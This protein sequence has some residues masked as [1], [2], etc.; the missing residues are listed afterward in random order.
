MRIAFWITKAIATPS[1]HVIVT[2]FP[3]QQWLRECTSMLRVYLITVSFLFHIYFIDG[4]RRSL[5]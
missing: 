2:V 1:V 3:R 4:E 5:F